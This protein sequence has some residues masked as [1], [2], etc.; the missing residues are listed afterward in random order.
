MFKKIITGLL[1]VYIPERKSSGTAAATE[2]CETL[3]LSIRATTHIH[4][5]VR[6][7]HQRETMLQKEPV[8]TWQGGLMVT[9]GA[10][11]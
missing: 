6:Q 1:S 2:K 9:P 8:V 10:I 5:P 4:A 3:L 11:T 7:R